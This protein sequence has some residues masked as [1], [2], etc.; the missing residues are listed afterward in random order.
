MAQDLRVMNNTK[1]EDRIRKREVLTVDLKDAHT[2]E[3]IKMQLAHEKKGKV[4]IV[5]PL[6]R[7]LDASMAADFKKQMEAFVQEGQALFILDLSEVAFVDS[8]GLGAIIACLK[9]VA[10]KGDLVI[11]GVCEKV[12]SLFKLTRM[13]RVFQVFPSSDEALAGFSS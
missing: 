8:T 12:I 4:V 5:K 7:H 11:A 2:W 3:G 9:M 10:G 6:D 1:S 13:D